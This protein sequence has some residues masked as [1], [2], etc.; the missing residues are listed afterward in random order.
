[1]NG[2]RLSARTV[3]TRWLFT[4]LVSL[5]GVLSIEAHQNGKSKTE[6]W[7][8]KSRSSQLAQRLVNRASDPSGLDKLNSKAK[9]QPFATQPPPRQTVQANSDPQIDGSPDDGLK[10]AIPARLQKPQIGILRTLDPTH[11]PKRTQASSQNQHRLRHQAA[12][13]QPLSSPFTHSWLKETLE[14]SVPSH[15]PLTDLTGRFSR[16]VDPVFGTLFPSVWNTRRLQ[17]EDQLDDPPSDSSNNTPDEKSEQSH[18]TSQTIPRIE[19]TP[20]SATEVT[21]T[22]ANFPNIDPS[23]SILTSNMMQYL[24]QDMKSAS[25]EIVNLQ[26]PKRINTIYIFIMKEVSSVNIRFEH[27]CLFPIVASKTDD[28]PFLR[29]EPRRTEGQTKLKLAGESFGQNSKNKTLTNFTC[30]GLDPELMS[31]LGVFEQTVYF[32]QTMPANRSVI[33]LYC[34][35]FISKDS[36][37]IMFSLYYRDT[38]P[39]TPKPNPDVQPDQ[40]TRS[41]TQTVAIAVGVAAAGV[42]LATVIGVAVVCCFIMARHRRE[43]EKA[44][45]ISKKT[46]DNETEAKDNEVVILNE[47]NL[48]DKTN[49]YPQQRQSID[50]ADKDYELPSNN[51]VTIYPEFAKYSY[52]G[53]SDNTP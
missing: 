38:L 14:A 49:V 2:N 30:P 34:P 29:V 9:S 51:E 37:K 12:S 21:Y 53:A 6:E 35:Y 36:W 24:S 8:I 1:M 16:D 19:V 20:D 7:N 47:K 28:L 52:L 25:I 41:S 26:L 10:T 50:P 42:V 3:K 4:M 48:P 22:L 18:E 5:Q 45:I 17:S 15:P 31:E 39:V 46:S 11:S 27:Q 33:M 23:P 13:S 40:E 43:L 32:S 44:A